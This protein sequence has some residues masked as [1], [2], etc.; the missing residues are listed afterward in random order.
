M[1]LKK[2]KE[3]TGNFLG[4]I[5]THAVVMV[6]AN[7]NDAQRQA[8]KDDGK[9][10]GLTIERVI[11][12]PTAATIACGLDKRDKEENIIVFDLG[13]GTIN[14]TLLSIKNGVFEVLAT[15]GDTHLGRQ[16]FDQRLM[17]Y[18]ISQFKRQSGI[19]IS[20]DNRAVTRLR[21]QCEN[22]K[23]M[24]F[25]QN[26]S[27]VEYDALAEGKTFRPVFYGPSSRN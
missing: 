16:D 2:M 22:A 7:F 13:G 26:S 12:K 9:N 25:S 14:A 3:T 20:K 21:K 19:D 5:V 8:T 24:L 4:L 18:F 1:V 17:S 23:R 6:P 27:T 10:A 15:A 11:N